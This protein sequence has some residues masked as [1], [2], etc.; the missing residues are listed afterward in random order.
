MEKL[1][2]NLVKLPE[3]DLLVVV[4]M[5]HDNKTPDT[6][7]KNDIDRMLGDIYI[8]ARQMLTFFYRGRISR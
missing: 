7:T 1:A 2:D 8:H 3:D 4:Q 6:Y 5:I